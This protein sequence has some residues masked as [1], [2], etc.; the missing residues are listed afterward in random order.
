[1]AHAENGALKLLTIK[2][3]AGILLEVINFALDI[4]GC[5]V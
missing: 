3:N 1:M 5:T 4:K 2:D